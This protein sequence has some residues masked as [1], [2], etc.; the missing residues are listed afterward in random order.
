MT[1]FGV[2]DCDAVAALAAE[3][4]GEVSVEPYDVPQI[5]RTAVIGDPHGAVF[6]IVTPN[7]RLAGLDRD[8]GAEGDGR[9]GIVGREIPIGHDD[10]LGIESGSDDIAV[11]DRKSA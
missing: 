3:L 6:S 8:R 11:A 7:A 10:E 9:S 2:D 4:G 1:Y 5:G